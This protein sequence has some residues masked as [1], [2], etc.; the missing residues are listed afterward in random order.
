M[1]SE[2]KFSKYLLYAIGEIILV[3]IG[4]LIALQINN[5]NTYKKERETEQ[6]YLMS[7]QTEF[8]S[9]LE[10]L[11]ASIDANEIREN[12]LEN[13]LTLF[14]TS[15]LDTVSSESI[16]LMLHP[17]LGSEL[18]YT[19]ALGVLSDII[20]SGKLNI[21][22]NK[23]LRHS[24]SSFE[25]SID[26]L[27]NQE[28]EAEK[29]KERLKFILFKK[30]SVRNIQKSLGR[31][32]EHRSISDTVNIKH[33]FNSVELEN[34]LLDYSLVIAAANDERFFGGLKENIEFILKQIELELD[35]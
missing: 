23:K 9:N 17:I 18:G 16:S 25:G 14:D 11:N 30:I 28:D 6:E 13:L 26:F 32:F 33:V 8:I 29:I 3:V 19:P 12:A 10:K 2:N 24:L 34:Y 27:K 21:I 1:L 35:K 20:S 22:L 5:N 15:I 4:I 31:Q 7:L